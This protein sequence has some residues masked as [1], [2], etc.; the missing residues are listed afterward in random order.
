[1]LN[2]P[3]G[4]IGRKGS[5]LGRGAASLSTIAF[6]RRMRGEGGKRSAATNGLAQQH[7][8]G[9]FVSSTALQCA[10]I[11]MP[12]TQKS[13]PDRSL[14]GPLPRRVVDQDPRPNNARGPPLELILDRAGRGDC[15]V[16]AR[17]L[18][19]LRQDTIV[20]AGKAMTLKGCAA[21]SKPPVPRPTSRR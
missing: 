4:F 6:R 20:L 17:L 21:K 12:P 10:S 2:S 7:G 16:R 19:D 14:Y 5:G 8:E 13:H 1:M 15:L 3:N 9:D 18:G 11:R